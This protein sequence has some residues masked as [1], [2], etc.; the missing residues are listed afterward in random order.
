M[1]TGAA[2]PERWSSAGLYC[3]PHSYIL[4]HHCLSTTWMPV[5][6]YCL[7]VSQDSSSCLLSYASLPHLLCLL[8]IPPAKNG[9]SC[10][11]KKASVLSTKQQKKLME[12]LN[13][14]GECFS[15][16]EFPYEKDYTFQHFPTCCYQN[17]LGMLSA[18]L[19]CPVLPDIVLLQYHSNLCLFLSALEITLDLL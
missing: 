3:F 8:L 6:P 2:E 19:S 15:T 5:S 10:L 17:I 13:F 11:W 1:H 7:I 16:W 4:C 12:S 18:V 9:I 14:T